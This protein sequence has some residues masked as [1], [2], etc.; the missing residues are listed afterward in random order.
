MSSDPNL[1]RHRYVSWGCLTAATRILF[2]H[3]KCRTFPC[4]ANTS[5]KLSQLFI[6]AS[7]IPLLYR[8]YAD[9]FTCLRWIVVEVMAVVYH[10]I[11]RYVFIL[12][13]CLC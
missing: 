11:R 12:V 6:L 9:V 4:V 7:I 8:I 5:L 3:H 13:C 1:L 10:N 2:R